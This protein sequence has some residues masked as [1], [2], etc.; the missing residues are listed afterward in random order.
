MDLPTTSAAVEATDASSQQTSQDADRSQR[1]YSEQEFN[2]AMAKMKAAVTKKVMK[3]L[4][5]LG[6]IDE[7]RQ[8]KADAERRRQEEQV[9]KGEFEKILQELAAKKDAEIVKRDRVIQEY[10]VDTPLVTVAA[11]LKSHNPDQVRTLLKPYVK[12]NAEGEVEIVD[13]EG[14]VRYNDKGQSYQVEDL[15]RE[16]LDS[17]PHFVQATPTT[18]ST[19]SSITNKVENLDITKL[20]MSNPEHRKI[21]AEYRKASGIR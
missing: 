7:L 4:E 16:F 20:N 21:Y 12:L 10:R 5:E 3:P 13:Q 8:L 18:A 17:N 11:K 14:R 2:D 6:D 19:R 9:K 1:V 15:V